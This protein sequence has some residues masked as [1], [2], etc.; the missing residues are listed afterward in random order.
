MKRPYP[1]VDVMKFSI[2]LNVLGDAGSRYEFFAQKLS[3]AERTGLPETRSRPKEREGSGSS[4]HRVFKAQ[5]WQ[6]S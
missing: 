5:H 3:S 6:S 2:A 4:L 1:E